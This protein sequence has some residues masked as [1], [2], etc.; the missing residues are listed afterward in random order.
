[1]SLS[2]SFQLRYHALPASIKKKKS[3]P[4]WREPVNS[5]RR[6]WANFNISRLHRFLQPLILSNKV[7]LWGEPEVFAN[8][9]KKDSLW[10]ETSV[11]VYV[12]GCLTTPV[13]LAVSA[14]IRNSP[15]KLEKPDTDRTVTGRWERVAS[16]YGHQVLLWQ[17]IGC[18]F[19]LVVTHCGSAQHPSPGAIATSQTI[20]TEAG[21]AMPAHQWISM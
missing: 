10:G 6:Y 13:E 2:Y 9:K 15:K 3:L 1:M 12:T 8:K 19:T 18:R 5:L 16:Q 11:S 14:W 20:Q 7:F 4:V 17:Q 21:P